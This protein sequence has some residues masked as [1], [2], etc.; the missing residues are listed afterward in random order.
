MVSENRNLVNESLIK[1][2]L[3]NDA[4]D[5]NN[6]VNSIMKLYETE[7]ILMKCMVDFTKSTTRHMAEDYPEVRSSNPRIFHDVTNLCQHFF[8]K[9]FKIG[10]ESVRKQL[11]GAL[12][13]L[14]D[15]KSATDDNGEHPFMDM[16]DSPEENPESFF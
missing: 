3:I 9:G 7:P 16:D 5:M 11:D 15:I 4:K 13:D 1:K 6:A 2:I 14:I 12:E 10:Q 8:L